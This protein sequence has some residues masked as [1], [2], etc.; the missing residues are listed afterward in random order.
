METAT[1]LLFP[2]NL[3]EIDLCFGVVLDRGRREDEILS[4][5]QVEY[6]IRMDDETRLDGFLNFDDLVVKRL[7]A[8]QRLLK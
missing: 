1:C 8:L 4:L 2:R 7:E 6:V 5:C 3:G